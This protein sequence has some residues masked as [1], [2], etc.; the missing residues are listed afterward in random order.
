MRLFLSPDVERALERR[1]VKD[2]RIPLWGNSM[3]EHLEFLKKTIQAQKVEREIER[4][5]LN[6]LPRS[7][8]R[9][10]PFPYELIKHIQ[11]F[12]VGPRAMQT[13]IALSRLSWSVRTYLFGQNEARI[14][15]RWK[16]ICLHSGIGQEPADITDICG[17]SLNWEKTA[18][19]IAGYVQ[20]GL[21]EDALLVSWSQME[22]SYKWNHWNRLLLD[23]A[24]SE[25]KV[26]N[27]EQVKKKNI[28]LQVNPALSSMRLMHYNNVDVALKTVRGDWWSAYDYPDA[29]SLLLTWPPVSSLDITMKDVADEY[30]TLHLSNSEGVVIWDIFAAWWDEMWFPVQTD[31]LE[32]FVE[33]D[34]G[35]YSS[36]IPT[37]EDGQLYD[38]FEESDED[39]VDEGDDDGATYG[40]KKAAALEAIIKSHGREYGLMYG[41]ILFGRK[42]W[43]GDTSTPTRGSTQLELLFD[44]DDF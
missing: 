24:A 11:S 30:H 6:A 26:L 32:Q 41:R 23:S 12:V 25:I 35:D 29:T 28:K 13:H 33:G 38:Y 14:E 34:R 1:G 31:L 19:S 21:C 10:L 5:R 40:E 18:T 37:N 22:K 36:S 17:I 16:Q 7:P 27:K 15:E 39:E 4:R 43:L 2:H 42:L 44:E 8:L 9:R 20:Y 3:N